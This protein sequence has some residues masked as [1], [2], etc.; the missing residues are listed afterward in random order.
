[1]CKDPI[2]REVRKAGEILAK[3][4]N[5]DLHIF[6]QNLRNNEERRGIKTVSRAENKIATSETVKSK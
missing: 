2:V 3:Q 4:A 1:M 6:F 5:Y